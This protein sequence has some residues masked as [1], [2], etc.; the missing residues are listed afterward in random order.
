MASVNEARN[1]IV[2]RDTTGA[3]T[4]NLIVANADATNTA[5]KLGVTF[6]SAATSVNSGSLDLQVLNE[7]TRLDSLRNGQGVR[8][9]SFTI[10]DTTGKTGAV[11]LRTSSAE[12]VGDVIELINGLDIAVEARINDTGDGILLADTAGGASTLTVIDSGT[13][14]SAEDL[15]IAGTSQIVDIGGTPTQVIDGT[16][17]TTVTIGAD[18][19]AG[20]C[21][22]ADQRARRSA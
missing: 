3:T 1:G 14:K 11:N 13:G 7:S 12:T 5:D 9:G 22:R 20:G 8:L 16:M 17:T 2:L 6:N 15:G 19:D 21:R 18:D 10:V 4:S